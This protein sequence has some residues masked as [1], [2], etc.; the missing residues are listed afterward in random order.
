MTSHADE[1]IRTSCVA[2]CR[3]SWALNVSFVT[4]LHVGDLLHAR[5]HRRQN[6]IEAQR[7]ARR[8]P[9]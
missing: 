8:A 1:S 2:M 7:L 5:P 4:P 6:G 9:T 3:R